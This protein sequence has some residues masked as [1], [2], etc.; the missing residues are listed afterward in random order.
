MTTRTFVV[1]VSGLLSLGQAASASAQV[2]WGHDR[3]PQSG[4]CFYEDRNFEGRY[5]CVGPGEDLPQLPN[6]MRDRISSMRVVGGNEVTVYQD[7]D[8]RGHSAHFV[9]DVPD[10]RREG[11]NDQISS[12]VVSMPGRSGAYGTSG[13]FGDRDRH[14]DRDRDRDRHGAWD[15]GRLPVWGAEAI[16]REGACFYEDRDFQGRSFC[17]PRGA[18][19]TS[20]PEG[21]NDKISSIRVFG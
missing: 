1:I 8:M 14:G 2:R 3:V 18:A 19:Y 9:G 15:A 21:F 13:V 10:L 12:I 5:F 17:V 11:W 16:P 20:L 6:D 7:R 4:A